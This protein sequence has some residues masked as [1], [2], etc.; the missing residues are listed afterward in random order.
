MHEYSITC[1]ILEILSKI[2]KE[3]KIKKVKVINF[4]ITPLSQIEPGSIEFYFNYFTKDNEILKNAKLSFKKNMI[5]IECKKCKKVFEINNF[6]MK[7][8]GCSSMEVKLVESDDIRI[9]SVEV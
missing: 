3:K 1:S 7:C 8:P 4:E 5:K 2:T 9:T 6:V